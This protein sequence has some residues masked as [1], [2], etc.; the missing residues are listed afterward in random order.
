MAGKRKVRH[1]PPKRVTVPPAVRRE[2]QARQQQI[3]GLRAQHDALVKEQQ[4]HMRGWAQG[5][6]VAIDKGDWHFAEDFSELRAGKPPEP[7]VIDMKDI[8]AAQAV[9]EKREK[10]KA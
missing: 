7:K 4:A 8:L 1:I 5:V 9:R 3:V 2:A 10:K 6:G